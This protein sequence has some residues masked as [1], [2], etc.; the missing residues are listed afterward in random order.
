MKEFRG[1]AHQ[2]GFATGAIRNALDFIASDNIAAATLCLHRAL[3]VIEAQNLAADALA[4]PDK[5][6]G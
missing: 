5:S 6:D 4:L 2:A 1:Y 3:D